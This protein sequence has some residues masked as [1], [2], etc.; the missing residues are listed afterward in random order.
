MRV[1]SFKCK[2]YG[3]GVDCNPTIPM[4]ARLANSRRRPLSRRYLNTR[5]TD[6]AYPSNKPTK[7][8]AV[9]AARYHEEKWW[10]RT[11]RMA[12]SAQNAHVD[13]AVYL[14]AS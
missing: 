1:P 2:A 12:T 10:T 9:T 3:G 5:A 11:Y 6:S 14:T 7:K 4:S 13:T 8:E